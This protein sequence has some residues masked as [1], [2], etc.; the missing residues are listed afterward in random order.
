[1]GEGSCADANNSQ[2]LIGVFFDGSE[3]ALESLQLSIMGA[4]MNALYVS[5]DS[6]AVVTPLH[7]HKFKF[8]AKTNIIHSCFVQHNGYC[9]SQR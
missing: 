1:M 2:R 6:S 3:G 8:A 5:Y 7:T 9:E 4:K